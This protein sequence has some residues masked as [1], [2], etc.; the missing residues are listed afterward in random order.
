M[1]SLL[2][3]DNALA[4]LY[5]F[6][7]LFPAVPLRPSPAL[8]VSSLLVPISAYD[9]ERI[10]GL[11]EALARLRKK[12]RS[13]YLASGVFQ[14]RLRIDLILLYSFCRVADDLVDEAPTIAEAR[15]WI[16]QLLRFLDTVYIHDP[17]DDPATLSTFVTTTFPPS[18]HTALLLFPTKYLP[19]TPLYDLVKGFETDLAFA[20]PSNSFPIVDEAALQKYASCVAGTVGESLIELVYHHTTLPLPHTQDRRHVVAAGRRMGKAL[21]Y[22]NIA[23]DI[24]VDARICRVYLPTSWLAEHDLTPQDVIT[25]PNNAIVELL[26]QRL[27]DVAMRVYGESCDAINELP[28]EARGPVHVAVESY[29]DIGRVLRRPGYKVKAGRATVPRLRRLRT[30]WIALSCG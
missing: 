11:Q 9:D 16:S 15:H 13:F 12:S 19:P 21:Q 26:R 5:A 28:V 10:Q 7:S 1:F 14:G 23:R 17:P 30:A 29:M 2:A 3:F 4:V 25:D 20:S 6:P 24:A 8:L 18:T 27:L 22:V